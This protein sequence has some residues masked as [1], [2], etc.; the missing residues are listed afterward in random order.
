M[1]IFLNSMENNQ[2]IMSPLEYRNPTPRKTAG[3]AKRI[4]AIANTRLKNSQEHP[5][6]H[7]VLNRLY[8]LKFLQG[9][10]DYNH[11]PLKVDLEKYLQSSADSAATQAVKRTQLQSY[12][13]NI[14]EIPTEILKP[15][16]KNLYELLY[17]KGLGACVYEYEKEA[18]AL[19][20]KSNLLTKSELNHIA[21]H[22]LEL[23]CQNGFETV[24]THLNIKQNLKKE[25]IFLIGKSQI[26]LDEAIIEDFFKSSSLSI[27]EAINIILSIDGKKN[28]HLLAILIMKTPLKAETLE[29]CIT[30][31]TKSSDYDGAQFLQD[32]LQDSVTPFKRKKTSFVKR[33]RQKLTY[34]YDYTM[35]STF[36]YRN[37]R[38]PFIDKLGLQNARADELT[39]LFEKQNLAVVGKARK[40]MGRQEFSEKKLLQADFEKRFLKNPE[41]AQMLYTTGI[42]NA[43]KYFGHDWEINNR[44]QPYIL[45][46]GKLVLEN[47]F[48]S[49]F[50]VRDFN[51]GLGHVP[52]IFEKSTDQV[53]EYSEKGLV[54]HN[55][56]DFLPMKKVDNPDGKF[57][58]SFKALDHG[59]TT[60]VGGVQRYVK[61]HSWLN[62][63]N[64]DGEL[65]SAG[66]FATGKVLSPDLFEYAERPKVEAK[67]EVTESQFLEVKKY[68]EDKKSTENP[69]NFINQNCSS[70]SLDIARIL[71]PDI[72]ASAYVRE[73]TG[74]ENRIKLFVISRMITDHII[75]NREHIKTA[76]ETSR[77]LQESDRTR[78]LT[79]AMKNIFEEEDSTT[80]AFE[81]LIVGLE[82][83]QSSEYGLIVEEMANYFVEHSRD[84]IMSCIYNQFT[85]IQR[86]S[87]T[88]SMDHPYKLCENLSKK[89]EAITSKIKQ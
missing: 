71:F 14:D 89:P 36:H 2:G 46:E 13:E 45:V 87:L 57:Y 81:D 73:T 24:Y 23:E 10:K 82:A 16:V 74:F 25:W 15:L 26:I 12:S 37:I 80:A 85:S 63:Q 60:S 17:I 70:F 35:W 5:T 3:Y 40:A 83:L 66:L 49:R 33:V 64:S 62:L 79:N 1:S 22:Y 65:Y 47:E 59:N 20:L 54:P 58:I 34:L 38:F 8:T 29:R 61:S 28:Y 30:S 18:L 56:L 86:S 69:F 84:E 42:H 75:E 41:F 32:L 39:P 67:F 19:L 76:I 11:L 31:L 52:K 72:D 53:F 43:M 55:H 27:N 50:E 78:L 21:K 77:L 7:H 88:H 44:S 48:L 51:I 4:K 6:T 9:I 68:I